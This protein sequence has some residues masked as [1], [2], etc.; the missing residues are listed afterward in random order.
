MLNFNLILAVDSYKT[1]QYKQYP[2]YTQTIHSYIEARCGGVFD[3]VLVAG[4]QAYIKKYL[5]TRITQ[6]MIDEADMIITGMGYDFNRAGWEYILKAHGGRMPLRIKSVAEG[7]LVDTGTVIL[8]VENTDEKCFWLTSYI[9]TGA[10]RG[11]WYMSTVATISYNAKQQFKAA[12]DVGSDDYSALP[13]RLHDFGARGTSSAESA[14]LG[15]IGHLMNFMGT[16]TVEGVVGALRYYNQKLAGFSVDA[17]EHST[18]TS[19]L[20]KGEA[21]AYQNM[22]TQFGQAGKMVSIVSDSYCLMGAIDIYETMKDDIIARGCKLVV[23]PDSG[24][25]TDILPAV[26]NR[27]DE[28]FGSDINTKGYKVLK[29][30]GV[31]WGDGIDKDSIGEVIQCVLDAGFSIDNVVLGMGGGLL[32]HCD[33]DWGRWAMKCSAA[34]VD[35]EWRDVYKAPKTDL[36]K[37]SKRGRFDDQENLRIT[38]ENGKLLIDETLTTIRERTEAQ[39]A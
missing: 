3:Q 37:T 16:D 31:L 34:Q 26:L 39:A 1:T 20:R 25:H 5:L 9:E 29:H 11:L 4:T 32:Q 19:W 23:R 17:S 7:T 33:R 27:L 36:T 6:E 22:I 10:L 35:G 12:M 18:I 15:G 28:I 30:C 8:V 14:E 38:F 2:S 24:T 13:F 21:G